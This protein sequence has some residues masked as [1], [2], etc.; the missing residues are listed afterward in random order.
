MLTYLSVLSLSCLSLEEQDK[1][2]T[3]VN[4]ANSRRIFIIIAYND[5]Q[6][7]ADGPYF[8]NLRENYISNI[9]KFPQRTTTGHLRLGAVRQ[10]IYFLGLTFILEMSIYIL[11]LALVFRFS[12][13]VPSSFNLRFLLITSK[14][15]R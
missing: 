4:I 11:K 12:I 9:E 6:L 7:T 14:H 13:C 5:S 3:V 15:S 1:I 10:R 2:N 8:S